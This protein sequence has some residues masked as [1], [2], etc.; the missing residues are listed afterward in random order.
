MYRQDLVHARHVNADASSRVAD[1]LPFQRSRA[2]IRL[3]RW[4]GSE[5]MAGPEVDG[6]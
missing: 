4:V 3:R 1:E 2:G 5:F 6:Q